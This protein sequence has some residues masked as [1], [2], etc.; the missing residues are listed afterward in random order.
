MTTNKKCILLIDDDETVLAYLV[1]KLSKLY[2]VVSTSDPRKAAGLART[3]LPDVIL[4][5]ID[6]PGMSG[7][8]VANELE[9]DSLTARIPFLYLTDL[10]SP[11]EARD[12][13][14]HV[15]G[16]PG[17]AKRAPMAELVKWIEEMA[18]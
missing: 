4:C 16:K 7:G 5:D 3:Q 12:L 14:G 8:D 9:G 13:G 15:G 18:A 17:I 1:P 11:E 6:M 10:V 2:E